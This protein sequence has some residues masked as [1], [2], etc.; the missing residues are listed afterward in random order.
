[1]SWPRFLLHSP[2]SS[3]PTSSLFRY[4]SST[5]LCDASRTLAEVPSID[6]WQPCPFSLVY[7]TFTPFFLPLPTS[8]SRHCPLPS[9]LLF[10]FSLPFPSP[11][12]EIAKPPAGTLVSAGRTGRLRGSAVRKRVPVDRDAAVGGCRRTRR[13][14]EESRAFGAD[15]RRCVFPFSFS[16]LSLPFLRFLSFLTTSTR[17]PLL[18]PFL[19]LKPHPP[20]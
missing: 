4:S 3:P 1:L 12:A 11:A 6:H 13:K 17:R 15:Q 2:S 10:V 5:R 18:G 20:Y 9:Q 8:P 14:F 16:P 7:L 19:R